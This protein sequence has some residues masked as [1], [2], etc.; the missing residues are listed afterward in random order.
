MNFLN[1][2]LLQAPQQ[3]GS[4]WSGILMI[5][6]IFVIFWLFFIR[7]QNKR[8]KE[9]QQFR[10]NLKKGDKIVTIGGIHGKVEEVRENTVLVSIDHNTKIEFEKSAIIPNA[11]QVGGAA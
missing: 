10:E 11:S 2:F 7:P 1:I 8:A 9:Q 3:Q 6:L 5:V 4:T